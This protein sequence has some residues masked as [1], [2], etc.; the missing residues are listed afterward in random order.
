MSTRESG[1]HQW[2]IH[3][4]H[5]VN[6]AENVKVNEYIAY[7]LITTYSTDATIKS[8]VDK[9]DFYVFPLV[10]PDGEPLE[11]FIAFSYTVSDMKF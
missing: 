8:Y 10:N 5:L 4:A 2:Y 1:L 7:Q 11:P 9:Y 6:Q 3:L